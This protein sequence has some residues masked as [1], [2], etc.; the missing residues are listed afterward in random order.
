MVVAERRK[1]DMSSLP[2]RNESNSTTSCETI[3]EGSE[4][5]FST[6][7]LKK[8]CPIN[9][10]TLP[11]PRYKSE[12][13]G[14]PLRNDAGFRVTLRMRARWISTLFRVNVQKPSRSI[15]N[16]LPPHSP[17]LEILLLFNTLNYYFGFDRQHER[18]RERAGCPGHL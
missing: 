4:R 17:W 13:T 15:I 14:W 8:L 1:Q 6:L 2:S 12:D 3:G 10:P 11:L 9:Q 18:C 5:Y 16:E 7:H